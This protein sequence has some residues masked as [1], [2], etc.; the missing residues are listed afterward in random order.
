MRDGRVSWPF[1]YFMGDGM[2]YETSRKFYADSSA[3]FLIL[4]DCIFISERFLFKNHYLSFFILG[5]AL[6]C[7]IWEISIIL[8]CKNE[9]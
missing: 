3:L 8:R 9:K 2:K 1:R 4:A 5:V 6:L 7:G